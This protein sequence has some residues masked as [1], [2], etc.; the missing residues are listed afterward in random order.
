MQLTK[1]SQNNPEKKNRVGRFIIQWPDFKT[2][3]KATV[4]NTV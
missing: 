3:Y 4:I 2:N 1:T